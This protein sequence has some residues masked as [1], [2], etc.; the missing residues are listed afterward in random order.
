MTGHDDFDRTLAAWFE[1]EA[2]SPAPAGG[3]DRVIDAARRR[4]PRPGLLAGPGS[5]WVGKVPMAG[6]SAGARSL[7]RSGLRISAALM[8]ILAIL[9]VVGGAILVGARLLQ[10]SPLL[11]GRLGHLAYIR[12]GAVYL[13][14][15]DGRNPIRIGGSTSSA[16]SCDAAFL[17]GEMWSPDGRYLAYRSTLEA[18]C[19]PT[20]HISDAEGNAVAAWP[21]GVGW[22]VAWAPDSMH[23]ATW[24]AVDGIDIH[25]VDGQLQQQVT[26]QAPQGYC[27]C[28]DYDPMWAPDGASLFVKSLLIP[29]DGERPRELLGGPPDRQVAVRDPSTSADGTLVAF[30]SSGSL[31]LAPVDDL[32][33]ARLLVDNRDIRAPLLSPAGDHIAVVTSRDQS[34]DQDGYLVSATSDLQVVDAA[35]GLLTTLPSARDVGTIGALAFSPDGDRILFKRSGATSPMSLWSINTDGSDAREL[36]PGA[37]WGDWQALPAAP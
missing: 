37:D 14:D 23:V 20:V 9:A 24:S 3:L 12:D 33:A 6:S 30:A 8:L 26:S 29:L 19:T 28:G 1:A 10:P 4:R 34:F 35:S 11:T 2:V 36:V 17:E 27:L 5:H 31:F 22:T 18:G 21:A 32:T 16:D 7:P 25:G 13:A 15:W